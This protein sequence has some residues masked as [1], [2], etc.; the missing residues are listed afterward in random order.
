[1]HQL[2]TSPPVVM[3][4]ESGKCNVMWSVSKLCQG[5]VEIRITG[6]DAQDKTIT[7]NHNGNGFFPHGDRFINVPITGLSTG[8]PYSYRAITRSMEEPVLEESSD[9]RPL[10]FVDENSTSIHFGIWND[11]HRE[12]ET[13]QQLDK[14]TPRDLDFLVWNGDICRGEWTE[15]ETILP[16]LLNPG[17]TDFTHGRP[18]IFMTGNHDARGKWAFKLAD[19][20]PFP[21]GK[22]YH[23][24]RIGPLAC[25]FLNTGEDKADGHPT[26]CGRVAFDPLRKEQA[27]WIKTITKTPH[28]KDAPYRIVICHIPLRWS[29]EITDPGYDWYSKRSR[30]LWHQPL[31]DWGVQTIISGHRHQPL[32]IPESEE[33]PYAQIVGGGP[34]KENARYIDVRVDQNQLMVSLRDLEGVEKEQMSFTPR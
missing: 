5:W 28:F 3:Y 13:I 23:A 7:F 4:P 25:L 19:I 20:L 10:Q 9:W 29:D 21:N 17:Q 8:I 15:E 31:V 26:F 14:I 24:L 33:F 18:L 34:L 1:M 6:D 27:E 11:T 16:S 12:D 2:M 30:D 32:C 22:S